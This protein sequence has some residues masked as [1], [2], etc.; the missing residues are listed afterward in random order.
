MGHGANV[1]D[2]VK[3][4]LAFR[5]MDF[6]SGDQNTQHHNLIIYVR[7]LSIN[8]LVYKYLGFIWV[9]VQ[10]LIHFPVL[11]DYEPDQFYKL[12]G[13]GPIDLQMDCHSNKC[14]FI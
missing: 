9:R 13:L 7:T 4:G 3:S 12:I 11:L 14:D 8:V 5:S 6:T 1:W 10:G 2:P